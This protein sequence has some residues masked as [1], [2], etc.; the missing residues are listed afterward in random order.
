MRPFQ[1]VVGCE[2]W[3]DLVLSVQEGVLIPRPKTEM[4]IDLVEDV[5]L[6]NASE[7]A[8]GVWAD[9]GTG[10]GAIAIATARALR[11]HAGGDACGR[12]AID[13]SL[14]AVAVATSNVQRYGLEDVVEVRKRS[15]FEPLK[16]V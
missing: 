2:H 11:S 5:A 13:L 1:Y 15:W 12:V 6:N 14:V 9:L 7:L 3:R 16:D 8:H 4:I 10:S